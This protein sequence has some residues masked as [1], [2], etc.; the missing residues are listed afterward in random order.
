M[1]ELIS[2]KEMEVLTP[3]LCDFISEAPVY[4][5]GKEII[6]QTVELLC[7]KMK[8][9][10]PDH[11]EEEVKGYAEEIVETVQT[12]EANL[13]ELREH[14]RSGKTQ[15][16]WLNQKIKSALAF[17]SQKKQT[18]YLNG[19][20]EAIKNANEN[21]SKTI[22]NINGEI[23]QLP[24]LDGL[25]AE[26]Y[27]AQTYNLDAAVKNLSD[28]ANVP[29]VNTRNS[30]DIGVRET[31][32]GVPDARYQLKYGKTSKETIDYIKKGDYRNQRLIVP[33][34]QVEEVQA[35]FPGR[36][37]S[38]EI[39]FDGAKGKQLTKAEAKQFQEE[40]QNGNWQ[41]FNWNEYAL[42][43]LAKGVAKQAG[44]AALIGAGV[45]A[46]F[47]IIG[48]LHNGEDIDPKGVA[49]AALENG[50]DFGVKAFVAGALKV[51]AEKGFIGAI[52]KGIPGAQ[53]ANIAF[54]GVENI[55][56][57]YSIA[58][59][60][61]NVS[62]G[63]RKMADV[64]ISAVGGIIGGAK[65]AALGAKAG[66]AV[67]CILPGAGNAIG[68]AVGAAVGGIVGYMAGSAAGKAVKT[69]AKKA[70]SAAVSACKK[71]GASISGGVKS[72]ASKI[73][74]FGKKVTG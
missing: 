63:L 52:P 65:G 49:K 55:K 23:N 7:K 45:G 60:K 61:Y 24:N 58:K 34:E 41:D 29:Q 26:Q 51:A 28:R 25:L 2:Q 22:H 1:N 35:A 17:M 32:G 74:S 40:A 37:V 57:M 3:L 43:D 70:A 69:G 31:P 56:V 12:N 30:M 11:S 5:P 21:F 42:R 64:T 19:L 68:A 47:E 46:G 13:S 36:K 8:E 38:A 9:N 54:I 20:D 27:H 71:I 33:A 18:E 66:A 4:Q 72:F 48:K 16:G 59:G 15:A 53:F 39:N 10:L 14:T 44:N 62:E 6:S 73:R 50:A 67:G